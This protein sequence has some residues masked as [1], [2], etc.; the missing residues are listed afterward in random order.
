MANPIWPTSLPQE[1]LREGYTETGPDALL[2]TEMESGPPIVRRR[3]TA[4]TQGRQVVYRMSDAQWAT[5]KTFFDTTISGG[6]LRF[7][8][9]DAG[10]DTTVEARIKPPYQRT[11]IGGGWNDV[12]LEIEVLP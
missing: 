7:D 10:N 3:F 5:F 4:A 12:T 6:A 1:P 11:V 9:P 2:R 8:W